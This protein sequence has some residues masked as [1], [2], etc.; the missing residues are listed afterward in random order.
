[1]QERGKSKTK[2][3]RREVGGF[4]LKVE[5]SP[6]EHFGALQDFGSLEFNLV[7]CVRE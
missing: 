7:K 5:G 1:M 2:G 4:V 3:E 6:Q